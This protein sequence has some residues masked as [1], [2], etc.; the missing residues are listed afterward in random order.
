[1]KTKF[2]LATIM[3]VTL[4][5]LFMV[6]ETRAVVYSYQSN[7]VPKNIPDW[8]TIY[9]SLTI[10]DS[11]TI[12]DV[13][14]VLNITHSFDTDLDVYLIAPNGTEV[15]LFSGVGGGGKNFTNTILDDEA[16]KPIKGVKDTSAPFTGSY[17][18]EGSL[19]VLDG[20]DAQGTWKL[21]I[22]DVAPLDSGSL[23]SWSLIVEGPEPEP[24]PEPEPVPPPKESGG[25][26][27]NSS[28]VPKNIPDTGVVVSSLTVPDPYTI[29]DVNVVLTIMHSY[30]SDLSATLVAPDGT[31]VVL[32]ANVGMGGTDFKNTIFNDEAATS[33]ADGSAPFMGSYKPQGSLGDFDGLNANGDW[34]LQI[35]DDRKLDSGALICWRLIINYAPVAKCHNVTVPAEKNRQANVTL[36]DIDFGSFDP[37]GDTITLSLEPKGPYTIGEHEVTLTVTDKDGISDTC[38][39]TVTVL[40]TV[41]SKKEDAIAMLADLVNPD[42]PND[43]IQMAIDDISMS[44][45]DSVFW[46]A[47]DRI[48]DAQGGE[49]GAD[50]FGYEQAACGL[51]DSSDPNQAE[52]LSLLVE[53]D[54]MIANAAISAAMF[55]G[56]DPNSVAEAKVLRNEGDSSRGKGDNCTAIAK[57]GEAWEKAA[58]TLKVQPVKVEEVP[59]LDYNQDGTIDL[60]DLMAFTEEILNILLPQS[61]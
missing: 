58:N 1:M 30:D 38:T 34:Q 10:P 39:S 18:P 7:D 29:A 11:F 12:L 9:S 53:A 23:N 26:V 36:E 56:N 41:Y 8:G 57:Y 60:A 31:S 35:S 32:F 6:T 3:A 19:A 40:P 51:L 43:P 2:K 47:S 59:T 27:Y 22:N 45:G 54:K 21:K 17:R 46:A 25:I 55:Q 24:E 48:A 5:S 52:A 37:D 16:G 15:K 4:L 44:L 14:V 28:D 50:V 61:E 42:D 13:N 49:D 33:I 20:L